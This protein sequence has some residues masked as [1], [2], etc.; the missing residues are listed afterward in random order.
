MMMAHTKVETRYL[1]LIQ[2]RRNWTWVQLNTE[3]HGREWEQVR[4]SLIQKLGMQQGQAVSI[5]L[6]GSYLYQHKYTFL[7]F[8]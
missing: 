3:Q 5:L 7:Y 4:S 1:C 6:F 2:Q 8:L